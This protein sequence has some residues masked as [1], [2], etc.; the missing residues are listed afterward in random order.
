MGEIDVASVKIGIVE[1]EEPLTTLI[2][3]FPKW[4]PRSCRGM[5]VGLSHTLSSSVGCILNLRTGSVSPQYHV[6]YDDLFTT[7]HNGET[8]G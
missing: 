3:M 6:V 8:G 5:F 2:S 1:Q 4:D 7:V